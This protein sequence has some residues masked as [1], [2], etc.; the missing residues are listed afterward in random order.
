MLLLW[1]YEPFTV[2]ASYLVFICSDF[3][4]DFR[5]KKKTARIDVWSRAVIS[6]SLGIVVITRKMS[7]CNSFKT[8]Y[9]PPI[10]KKNTQKISILKM[11]YSYSYFLCVLLHG[12]SPRRRLFF[13]NHFTCFS[14]FVIHWNALILSISLF[15]FSGSFSLR[16]RQR[17]QKWRSIHIYVFDAVHSSCSCSFLRI[18]QVHPVSTHTHDHVHRHI[19]SPSTIFERLDKP[20]FACYWRTVARQRLMMITVICNRHISPSFNTFMLFPS[21]RQFV[22]I[23]IPSSSKSNSV[24]PRKRFFLWIHP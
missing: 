19:S 5:Q 22:F 17:H 11:F 9:F 21:T 2:L 6:L 14:T 23:A 10:I 3:L 4:Q 13:L 16:F 1:S 7:F 8:Y 15:I 20:H 18:A 12:K 24:V